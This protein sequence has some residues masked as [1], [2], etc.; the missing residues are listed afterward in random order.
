[1]TARWT[2]A[3]TR[4]PRLCCA[5]RVALSG[6]CSMRLSL[7]RGAVLIAAMIGLGAVCL[8][9]DKAGAATETEARAALQ[10]GDYTQAIQELQPLA[11]KG[12]A[13]AQY[14]LAETY[15]GGHGGSTTEALKWMTASAQQGYVQ[16]EARLGLLYATGRGVPLNNV[17]AYRWF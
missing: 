2:L 7:N 16:A 15:F 14:L 10:A 3:P 9:S 4:G 17:E 1:M 6:S 13:E 5:T 11:D 8:P 12:D